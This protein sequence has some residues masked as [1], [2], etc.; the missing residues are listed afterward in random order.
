MPSAQ[1]TIAEFWP[2]HAGHKDVGKHPHIGDDGIVCA[3]GELLG[4]PIEDEPDD[5]GYE[6]T[7][8]Q[9]TDQRGPKSE[10]G[11]A[12]WQK[13]AETVAAARGRKGAFGAYPE[14][15]P[16]APQEVPDVVESTVEPE[17][18]EG[19]YGPVEIV[20]DEFPTQAEVDA[21]I[22]PETLARFQELVQAA[23]KP[24]EGDDFVVTADET[25]DEAQAV[26]PASGDEPAAV[27]DDGA[28]WDPN[29]H[30][31]RYEPEPE[32]AAGTE[33]V[34]SETTSKPFGRFDDEPKAGY[35]TALVI[36]EDDAATSCEDL[37]MPDS[38]WCAMHNHYGIREVTA[39]QEESYVEEFGGGRD[40]A[41]LPPVREVATPEIGSGTPIMPEPGSND[42]IISDLPALDS[43]QIYTPLDV[44]MQMVNLNKRLENGEFFL[45]QQLARN[46][47]AEHAHSIKY[48]KAIKL[49]TA[50]SAD[51]RKADAT[52]SCE[53]ESWEMT[54]SATLVRCTRDLLHTIRAQLSGFQSISRSM[55]TTF[56]SPTANTDRSSWTGGR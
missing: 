11:Q 22:R 51:Q 9:L 33:V 55:Q 54:E 56:T 42:P 49:S 45:R 7:P 47:A 26:H 24:V 29:A 37:A 5:D 27:L 2:D 20:R 39:R 19:N 8:I 53:R 35:C 15:I 12:V 4:W 25:C 3:C 31:Y 52:I 10:A 14:I 6:P 17:V 28:T 41:Q 30:A 34:P 38:G 36:D 50:R 48:A 16:E 23:R 32:P 44:E 18:I 43:T 1:V 40:V 46:H 21:V 13:A